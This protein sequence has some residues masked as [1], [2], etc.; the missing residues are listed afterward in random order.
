MMLEA[1]R[2]A[3]LRADAIAGESGLKVLELSTAPAGV[4]QINPVD[5]TATSG[6]G[7]YDTTCFMNDIWV[8]VGASFALE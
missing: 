2:G 7:N 3:R 8:T 5:S 1:T 6:E 4:T